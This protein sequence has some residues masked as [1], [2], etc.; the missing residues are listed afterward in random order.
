MNNLSK[1]AVFLIVSC[2]VIIRLNYFK[3]ESPNNT[4]VLTWDAFGYYL[5]LP[6]LFI[7]HDIKR[8][9]WV[10]KI[11]EQYQTTGTLYQISELPNGNKV[12]KYLIGISI[13]YSPFF[14]VGHAFAGWL[15][16]P[17]DGFSSPYQIA[18]CIAALFYV[19]LG[20]WVLRWVLLRYFSDGVTALTL[21]LV[22]L[23]TNYVQY[24]SLDSAMSHGFIFALYA[25]LLA[26]T[27]KWHERPTLAKAFLIGC[28]IG[29]GVI[30]R[31]T[32]GVMLFI[33][34]LYGT[35]NIVSKK[36]KWTLVGKNR[37]HIAAVFIGGLIA[38]FPQ[39]LYWKVVTGHWVHEVVS[40]W[41]F[42]KPNWQV[43]FGWEKG[44]FVYT[45][46]VLLM[47]LGLFYFRKNPFFRSVLVFF[48]LNTWIV[49]AWYDWRY[50]ASYSSRAL[51][52]SYA[53]MS[54]PM[55]SIIHKFLSDRLKYIILSVFAFLIFLNLFQIWQYN[56]GIL[57]YNDMNRLYYMAIFLNPN[58]TPL[59]MSLLDT[60]EYLRNERKYILE[61]EVRV[62]SQ[63]M[64]NAEKTLHATLYESELQ[65]IPG[66]RPNTE[67]W[68]RIK[69]EVLSAWGAYDTNLST[70]L[71]FSNESKQTAC[72]MQNG[73]SQNMKWNIIEYYFN[74]PP[75]SKDGRITIN[76]ETKAKQ[77]I[78]IKNLTVKLLR[79]I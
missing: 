49:I 74:L 37:S 29:L 58:P 59:Q 65:L 16:F 15:G 10:P 45:P 36:A 3:L 25:F 72:R 64:V 71:K 68:M 48:I 4:Q 70:H 6:G 62:D 63:F 55:A 56:K 14:T 67:Q 24:V 73:T 77:N 32:E 79:K 43:L 57:H 12:M 30:S 28:I 27:I 1:I 31:P 76:V 26:A 38:V 8:L 5:C 22:S 47:V 61:H 21:I 33:P 17:Q 60:K 13:L 39:L 51:V 78:F 2:L 50:G 7:Y 46:A 52:Q 75:E 42:F 9:E 34:L 19:L 18:V 41:V 40:K 44:L 11:K 23:A 35:Q 53:V 66:F 20:L 54:L 69:V